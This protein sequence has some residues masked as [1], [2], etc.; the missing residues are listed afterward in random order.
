MMQQGGGAGG[1]KVNN[2]RTVDGS[3]EIGTSGTG[4]DPEGAQHAES[5][6]GRAKFYSANP[7]DAGKLKSTFDEIYQN[8]PNFK[9]EMDKVIIKHGSINITSRELDPNTLGIARVG[10]NTLAIDTFHVHRGGADLKET[11]AHEVLHNVG[12]QHGSTMDAAI[13]NATDTA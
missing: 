7:A 5:L 4:S 10:G 11:L 2:P 12:H 6:D 1:S 9:S 13:H 8:D 3:D